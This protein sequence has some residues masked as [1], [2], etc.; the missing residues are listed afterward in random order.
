MSTEGN[1]VSIHMTFASP[2]EAVPVAEALA[3]EGWD[4]QMHV[5][6]QASASGSPE[7]LQRL[8][9]RPKEIGPGLGLDAADLPRPS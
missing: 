3:N 7:H 8:H 2:R 1:S 5:V 6:L 4:V 9:D